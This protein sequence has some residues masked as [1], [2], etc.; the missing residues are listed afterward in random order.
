MARRLWAEH[1]ETKKEKKR[2][3][4]LLLFENILAWKEEVNKSLN[5]IKGGCL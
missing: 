1:S 5:G 2:K 4:T 3:E